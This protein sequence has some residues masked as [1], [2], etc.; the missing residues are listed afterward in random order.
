MSVS[1]L[2]KFVP[3]FAKLVEPLREALRQER[4]EWSPELTAC[5]AETKQMIANAPA[6]SLFDHSL[7]TYVTTDASDVGCG[8]YLSQYCGGVEK[9]IAYA[10]KTF[11]AAERGYS[12]VEREALCCVWAVEKWHVYLWGRRF[13]LR[14]DA[15]SL[16]II[17]GPKGSNRAGRRIARWE[18]R[19]MAYSFD[20]KYLKSSSNTIADGL[21]R[22]P[23]S[24]EAWTDDDCVVIASLSTSSDSSS[25]AVTEAELRSASSEDATLSDVREYVHSGRWPKPA[26]LS[27]E[28]KKFFNVRNELSNYGELLFRSDRVV[29]PVSL[30]KH[31]VKLA[32]EMHQGLSRTKRLL[33]AVYWWPGLDGQVEEVVKGCDLCRNHDAHFSPNRPPLQPIELPEGP[34]KRVMIDFI[35]PL[36]GPSEERF[37][38]VLIDMFSRWPEVAFSSD[39]TASTTV[40][41][42]RSLFSREGTVEEIVSDN[43]PQF[44]S[45][46]L[47]AFLGEHGI[48]HVFSSTYSPQTCGM[49]ERMNRT[50]KNAILSA[51][52]LGQSR[53][54]YV[55]SFLLQYRA[56]VHP[57]TGISP[58]RA[59]RGRDMR[60][61]LNALPIPGSNVTEVREHHSVYQRKY[62][63]RY[64]KAV[65]GTPK[66][67]SGDWVRV[68]NPP[69]AARGYGRERLL[70]VKQTGPVSY[71]LSDG[72]R[73]H[74]RR[75]ASADAPESDATIGLY[76]PFV[77]NDVVPPAS[78]P[79][80]PRVLRRSTRL[81]RP[82]DRFVP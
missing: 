65:T 45:R 41:F 2:S 15:Q 75:L 74:A 9:I 52:M 24:C 58:F 53:K 64:N 38:L 12:V 30:R 39:C 51:K 81:R 42:L 13:T 49:V 18:A 66:W 68:K 78:E 40:E 7:P 76:D 21:S 61:K 8:A 3:G 44:R 22:L 79:I 27:P 73:V 46:E 20:V 17:F 82:P 6:L 5:I 48:R 60:T 56:T 67:K 4:F 80:E 59:M 33:R 57:A 29:A 25:G 72:Q 47:Q 34:W 62:T 55:R 1:Y 77:S 19:L 23:R 16:T 37:G 50:I 26:S 32:H 35:G 69:G 63:D 36:P 10:S 43:G 70:V 54:P 14:T 71:T 31:L 28:V 11:T